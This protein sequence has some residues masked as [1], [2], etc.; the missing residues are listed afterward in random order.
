MTPVDDPSQLPGGAELVDVIARMPRSVDGALAFEVGG[1]TTIRLFGPGC[2][3]RDLSG[4]LEGV[5][6]DTPVSYWAR[7]HPPVGRTQQALR[8]LQ[9]DPTLT[10]NA[11]A[12]LAGVNAAAVY[13]ALERSSRPLC[14]CCGQ[15][16][17]AK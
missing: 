10:P 16:L 6:P 12:K 3:W 4:A 13:R 7:H 11:A 17:P 14:Q 9:Q 8:L 2:L 5:S 1:E 15:R